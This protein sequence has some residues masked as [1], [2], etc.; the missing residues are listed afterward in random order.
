MNIAKTL[1]AKDQLKPKPADENNLGFGRIFTDHM[2]LMDYQTGKGWHNPRVEPYGPFTLDPAAMIFHYGQ[3]VF[4]GLKAYRGEGGHVYMFR[5]AANIERMNRSCDRLCIPA[6]PNEVVLEAMYELIRLEQDWIPRAEGTSLYVRPTIIAT[7]ACL[8]V[9]TSATYLFYIITG[10]VGA[11]YAEGFNPVRI[12][13]EEK[14][15]RAAIGGTGEAKTA[16]NYASSLK[17]ATE[18]HEKGFTQVLWLNACDRQSIE[19]VG[20]MNIFFKIA[21][22]V[23]TSP[24]DGSILPGVTRDSVLALCRHWGMNV[25][26]RQLTI[27]DIIAAAKAGTLEEAF[28]TGTAAVISPVGSI[29]FKGQDYQVADGR[30]G[31]LSLKLYDEITGIQ[32]GK[33]PDPFGWVVKVA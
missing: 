4:E 12:W 23:I 24:L 10:P 28:G 5:P 14:Y 15:V 22:E 29:H 7:E 30:T 2:L 13:V 20:T 8:G 33:K 6:L 32:L 18:A 25:S 17:A 16:G 31:A 9:K 26:E 1:K 3:E 19:E 21:G 11:Y 27:N